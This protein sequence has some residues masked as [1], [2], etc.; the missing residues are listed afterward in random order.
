MFSNAGC[1]DGPEY[2]DSILQGVVVAESLVVF[3]DQLN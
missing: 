1:V 2:K 3:F